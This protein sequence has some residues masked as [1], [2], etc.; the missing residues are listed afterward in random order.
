VFRILRNRCSRSIGI[1]VQDAPEYACH[2]VPEGGGGRRSPAP[3]APLERLK[4]AA[5]EEGTA[6]S[7]LVSRLAG[8]WLAKRK[9]AHDLAEPRQPGRSSIKG[10]GYAFLRGRI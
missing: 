4:I 1:G 8:K 2:C 10:F 6:V 3:S 7:A 5:I 9:G